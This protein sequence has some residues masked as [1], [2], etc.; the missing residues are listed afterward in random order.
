MV[1]RSIKKPEIE[2]L[3]N[4]PNYRNLGNQTLQTDLIEQS[5]CID[6]LSLHVIP[7]TVIVFL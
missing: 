1:C 7:L 4:F 5:G 6:L 2:D 3:I